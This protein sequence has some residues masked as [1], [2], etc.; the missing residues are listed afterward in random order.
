MLGSVFDNLV[1]E[2]VLHCIFC[3]HPVVAVGV[4]CDFFDGTA[5]VR[6]QNGIQLVTGAENVFRLNLD[7]GSL[8]LCTAE[9]LMDHDL[10]V[11]KGKSLSGST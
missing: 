9:G 1:D 2:T 7:V 4:P 6:C 5:G 11:G 8:T 3:A 10:A